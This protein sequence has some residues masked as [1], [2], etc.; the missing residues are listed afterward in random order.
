MNFRRP[1]SWLCF[2][3]TVAIAG[4]VAFNVI[5]YVRFH[6]AISR[7]EALTPSQLLAIGEYSRAAN[8]LSRFS[9]DQIPT[10]FLPLQP[11]SAEIGPHTSD[12]ELYKLGEIHVTLR[13]TT[14]PRNQQISYFSN[15][16]FLQRSKTLWNRNPEFVQE[17]SPSGRL[18]TITQA[19]M[20]TWRDWIVLDDRICVVDRSGRSGSEDVVRGNARL[21]TNARGR[22]VSALRAI[23]SSMRGH[24][25]REAGTMDGI[26]LAIR[27][28]HNGDKGPDDISVSNVWVEELRPLIEAIS[29]SAPAGFPID[30]EKIVLDPE[31]GER[32][33]A[34][35]RTLR[36]AETTYDFLHSKTPWWCIWRSIL[37]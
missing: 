18:L 24:E 16:N 35:I 14:S 27:T 6:R 22:I 2:A 5:D 30:F 4:I 32:P 8:S 29:A 26:S 31:R 19:A 11:I 7:A 36:D 9:R 13:I 37:N 12:L 15:S 1:L 25:Y 33:I 28:S 23:P 10:P 21:D 34:T 3:A 20:T 17:V